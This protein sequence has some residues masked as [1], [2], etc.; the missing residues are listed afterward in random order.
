MVGVRRRHRATPTVTAPTAALPL[1]PLGFLLLALGIAAAAAGLGRLAVQGFVPNGSLDLASVGTFAL[2]VLLIG[3]EDQFLR[4]MGG[5][6]K[7]TCVAVADAE[8]SASLV[9]SH[10]ETQ[11]RRR[12]RAEG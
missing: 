1:S 9:A 5:R 12:G 4:A 2:G 10:R 6:S 3:A 11:P 7:L 8:V